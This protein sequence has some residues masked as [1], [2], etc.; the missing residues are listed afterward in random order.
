MDPLRRFSRPRL[1][2][3]RA[4]LAW[5]GWND[6]CDAASGSAAYLLGSLGRARTLSVP[7]AG[8]LPEVDVEMVVPIGAFV[9]VWASTL[10]N[11]N[12]LAALN[13]YLAEHYG[14]LAS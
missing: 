3:P 9:D 12:G 5:G 11:R 6:A 2:S 13:P 7:L 4:L 1:R 10:A 14:L 8:L